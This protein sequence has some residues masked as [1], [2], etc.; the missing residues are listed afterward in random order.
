M[1]VLRPLNSK[2]PT[3]KKITWTA[4][5]LNDLKRENSPQKR[6]TAKSEVLNKANYSNL[7]FRDLTFV[8]IVISST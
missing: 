6:L 7:C 5:W 4:L 1:S 2:R 3:C 8:K